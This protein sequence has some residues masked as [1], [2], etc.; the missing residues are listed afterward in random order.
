MTATP[1][2]F[3]ATALFAL[4]VV[5]TFSVPLFARLAHRNGP[6]AGFW[7]M[8]SEVE[9]VFGLW[10]FVLIVAMAAIAG[11]A[12]AVDY[13]DTR[14]FT[15][16]L[17]VFAIMVVAASRPIIELVGFLVRAVAGFVTRVFSVRRELAT[18]FVVLSLVPLAGSFITEPAAMT[19]A[20]LLLRDA[21]FN[22]PGQAGFKYLTLGVL[23]VNISIGGVLTAYAAPPVL[24][25]ATTFQWD[26][27]HMLTQFGWRAIAAV[28]ANAL[29]LTLV[30]RK[31]LLASEIGLGR[32]VGAKDR[33]SQ[34]LLIVPPIC[35]A[36]HVFFLAAIVLA[37]HHPAVFLGLFMM[38]IGYTEAY[39]RFQSRLMVKEGLMVGFFL[40]GLVVL[41]GLQK[42][43][44]QDLLG[45]LSPTVLY[46]GAT[47]LTAVTDNAALT[48]LGSLVEGTDAAWR[49][50]LVAGAVTGGGLTVIA[51]APNPAGFAILK[52]T[53]PNGTIAAG[54]LF[55]SAL[56]PTL[57]AALAFFGLPG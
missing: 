10:A 9:A 18:F 20:A 45:S 51:N 8:I 12:S 16:P 42:W 25:V 43:W 48:Y 41:G 40:A 24:M 21:Y 38:F 35:M 23:F 11:P 13:L 15:E 36:V 14:N 32:G 5:H 55:V 47:L 17:F 7:H 6:H 44:L 37:A 2:E 31:A 27:L 34:T 39:K 49:Y 19:L 57:V 22:R 30:C 29:I 53:F 54:P 3:I 50:M 26:T 46:W 56:I 52:A 4:A 28:A 1:L 33:A